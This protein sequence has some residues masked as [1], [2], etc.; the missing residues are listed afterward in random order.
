[1]ARLHIPFISNQ[2]Q[3]DK[4]VQ[5]Y[6]HT[7]GGAIF[8]TNKGEIVYSLPK[9][10][11]EKSIPP[12]PSF[13]H[14]G[15]KGFNSKPE[16]RN[17]KLTKVLAL[18][19][20]LVDGKVNTINGE[21]EAITKVSYFKGSDRSKWKINIPTYDVVSLGEVYKG[22]ELRLRAYGNNVE[23]LFFVNPGA[24]P[25]KIR[26]RLSGG[27]DVRI[28]ENGELEVWTEL[29]TVKF[30][31]PIAY[32]ENGEGKKFVEASYVIKGNEYG[33]RV[34]DYDEEKALVI[35]PLLA[36]TFLGGSDFVF[37]QFHSYIR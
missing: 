34:G 5:F 21:G 10:E 36:S 24:E 22:V 15:G 13:P 17:S 16:T 2:G 37:R 33:F 25:Q 35:D 12:I 3:A 11:G 29:G 28:N 20:E 32:Q 19:E 18:K 26:V 4:R 14:K 30:T 6:A 27:K 1:M 31:K 8:I 7:F 9:I 23:K